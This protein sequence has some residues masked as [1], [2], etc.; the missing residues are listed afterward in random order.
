MADVD[1][2]VMGLLQGRDLFG[3]SLVLDPPNAWSTLLIGGGIKG[4]R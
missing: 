2:G 1:G 3:L 4:A